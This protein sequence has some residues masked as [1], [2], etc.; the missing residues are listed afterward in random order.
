MQNSS[1]D[2]DVG[3][4]LRIIEVH[5]QEIIVRNAEKCGVYMQKTGNFAGF[6]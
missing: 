1:A 2:N 4:G 3:L 5:H 6:R